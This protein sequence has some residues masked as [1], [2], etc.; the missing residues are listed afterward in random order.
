VVP[1]PRK[2]CS[3]LISDVKPSQD[4]TELSSNIEV[5]FDGHSSH[6]HSSTMIAIGKAIALSCVDEVEMLSINKRE[7]N[8]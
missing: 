2:N 8:S 7:R 4:I 3:P 5:K 6:L 1:D